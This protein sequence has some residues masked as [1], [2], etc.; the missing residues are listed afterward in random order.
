M[1]EKLIASI[2]DGGIET[3]LEDRLH[4]QLPEFA[5]FVLLE[6]ETGRQA[7]R[8]YF[9]PFLRIAAETGSPLILDTPTWRANPDWMMRVGT[10]VDELSRI[11]TDAVDLI[12]SCAAEVAPEIPL[13]VNGCIGPRFDEYVAEQRMSAEAAEAYHRPQVSALARAGAD[14]VT[15]V[16]T[17]DEAEAIGVVRAAV[18]AEVPVAVSFTVEPDG[19][20]AN[21]ASLGDAI[22]A[23][24]RATDR[25]P[26]GYLV[27]CAH[28][29]EVSAALSLSEPQARERVLGFRLNAAHA[30][31]EGAGDHPEAFA[32][33]MLGLRALAPRAEVFGGC[34]GTDT[35]HITEIARQ[36]RRSGHPG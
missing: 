14:R 27:N 9:E 5:A 1:T 26:L 10:P 3:A 23:V 8:D 29:D 15:S 16:T 6:S 17:L 32:R 13:T 30:G 11:N 20:L 19:R 25:A 28:P 34:C 4:Q 7:L 31:E 2:A 22:D 18:A 21:G 12:R 33:G 35:P 36:L 24:D